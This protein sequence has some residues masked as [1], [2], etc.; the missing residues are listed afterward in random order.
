MALGDYSGAVTT[1]LS[2]IRRKWFTLAVWRWGIQAM[3]CVAITSLLSTVPVLREIFHGNGIWAVQTAVAVL[4]ATT[5]A[6]MKKSAERMAGT[7]VGGVGAYLFV[8]ATVGD[9]VP[10]SP[11]ASTVVLAYFFLSPFFWGWVRVKFPNNHLVG[12]YGLMTSNL[13]AAGAYI[14]TPSGAFRTTLFRIIACLIGVFVNTAVVHLVVPNRATDQ[15][16]DKSVKLLQSLAE[17]LEPIVELEAGLEPDATSKVVN[18]NKKTLREIATRRRRLLADRRKKRGNKR[19]TAESS[20]SPPDDTTD[21][22][23]AALAPPRKTS[24]FDRMVRTLSAAIGDGTTTRDPSVTVVHALTPRGSNVG[25]AQTVPLTGTTPAAALS[26]GGSTQLEQRLRPRAEDHLHDP[27]FL[28]FQRFDC[29]GASTR[30]ASLLSNV[31]GQQQQIP[32]PETEFSVLRTV[33]NASQ[34]STFYRQQEIELELWKNR[35]LQDLATEYAR[36]VQTTEMERQQRWREA[37]QTIEKCQELQ[38]PLPQLLVAARQEF[39]VHCPRLFPLKQYEVIVGYIQQLFHQVASLFFSVDC[40]LARASQAQHESLLALGANSALTFSYATVSVIGET[41]QQ[42]PTN[43]QMVSKILAGMLGAFL[44]TQVF[45]AIIGRAVGH[46]QQAL[47]ELARAFSDGKATTAALHAIDAA[48]DDIHL[49]CSIR[50]EHAQAYADIFEA[51]LQA[52]TTG[53]WIERKAGAGTTADPTAPPSAGDPA[54]HPTLPWEKLMGLDAET[55]RE[56]TRA[57]H[58]VYW[59]SYWRTSDRLSATTATLMILRDQLYL[60]RT[61]IDEIVNGT[62]PEQDPAAAVA[63]I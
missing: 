52:D 18:P 55:F 28:E 43:T 29:D 50:N 17:I 38:G 62:T 21:S 7:A 1:R 30:K 14:G 48:T 32:T 19:T 58:Q 13:I 40:Q 41:G 49:L 51:A 10:R 53:Y 33:S 61:V 20:S 15:L 24:V 2:E 8:L 45:G 60:I 9:P 57:E 22:P 5:G 4:E 27:E 46:I 16:V 12:V 11:L 3:C 34:L 25:V 59:E 36:E 6:S 39:Q 37:M 56:M 31:T 54:R 44:F 23:A 35:T 42:L 63:V 47:N 26:R